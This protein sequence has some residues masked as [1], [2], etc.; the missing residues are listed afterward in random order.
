MAGYVLKIVDGVGVFVAPED[1]AA[2]PSE[3]KKAP[4]KK[5]AS[6]KTGSK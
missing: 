3:P 6:S 4:A 1:A 5:A 2:E